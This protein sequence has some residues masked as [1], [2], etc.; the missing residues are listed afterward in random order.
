MLGSLS[1]LS[2]PSTSPVGAMFKF[3]LKLVY[4]SPSPLPQPLHWQINNLLIGLLTS[5]VCFSRSHW[6]HMCHLNYSCKII[7]KI[8]THPYKKHFLGFLLNKNK[9][10]V[11]NSDRHGSAWSTHLLPLHPHLHSFPLCLWCGHCGHTVLLSVPRTDKLFSFC[12]AVHS[13]LIALLVPP[14]SSGHLLSQG[15]CCPSF[16]RKP[17]RLFLLAVIFVTLITVCNYST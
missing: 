17:P 11:P 5:S 10:R 1:P 13:L 16:Q 9:I 2:I 3:C 12:H 4:F 15:L 8:M 7:L 6:Y 14:P